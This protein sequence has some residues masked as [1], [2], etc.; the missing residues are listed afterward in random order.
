MNQARIA[1]DQP[2][3]GRMLLHQVGQPLIGS[4][5]ARAIYQE[6][7][8]VARDRNSGRT[9]NLLAI[10]NLKPILNPAL[11][12]DRT[13]TT[14]GH[15]YKKTGPFGPTEAARLRVEANEGSAQLEISS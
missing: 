2:T 6:D 13:D 11:G 10:D 12:I 5:V 1:G 8:S 9:A 4:V 7:R 15:A 3:G 14:A